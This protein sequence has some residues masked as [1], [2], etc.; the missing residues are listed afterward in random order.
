MHSSRQASAR[1]VH[2]FNREAVVS[3][4]AQ[5]KAAMRKER[6]VRC[7]ALSNAL[8]SI[9]MVQNSANP[10]YVIDPKSHLR[11]ADDE[12]ATIT[13]T[14][15]PRALTPRRAN[16]P[17]NNAESRV[18]ALIGDAP[19]MTPRTRATTPRSSIVPKEQPLPLRSP[20]RH[21]KAGQMAQPRF[22]DPTRYEPPTE[23]RRAEIEAKK[24]A[25][26]ELK[27]KPASGRA[28]FRPKEATTMKVPRD[29]VP[30][31]AMAA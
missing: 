31:V 8:A 25:E 23:S 6:Q 12:A 15:V 11:S 27:M 26:A 7:N 24:R 5:E 3:A 29:F 18:K 10:M 17:Q 30:R 4:E 21:T 28:V 2:K 19:A 22:L 9:R 16:V 1:G 20:P 13:S 14:S